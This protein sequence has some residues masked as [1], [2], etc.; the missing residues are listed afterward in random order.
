[1][2]VEVKTTT[3]TNPRDY[4]GDSYGEQQAALVA[5]GQ[6]YPLPFKVN[7]KA[8]DPLKPG[9]Y[10]L[11]PSGF[12]T[13]THGNLKLNKVRLVAVTAAPPAAAAKQ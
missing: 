10:E 2:H 13:D 4:K 6:D 9:R 5:S 1:M 11:D 3:I 12:G 7:R 8:N